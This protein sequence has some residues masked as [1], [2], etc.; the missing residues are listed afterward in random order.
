MVTST[1]TKSRFSLFVVYGIVFVSFFDNHSLLPLI[2]PYARSLGA[3]VALA[4]LIVGAYSA[5]NLLGN[6]GAGYWIDRTGRKLPLV[7]GL[8]IVGFALLLYPF[9][10]DPYA[11][12]GLRTIHGLGAALMSPASLAYIGDTATPK[13]RGRAMALYGAAIGL[14]VLIGPPLAGF[15]RDR[16]GYAYVFAMLSALMFI[17]VVPAYLFIGESFT[18]TRASANQNAWQ[19]L[20]NRRLFLAYTSAF[21]LMFSLGSLIVFLPLIGQ[22]LGLASSR[23]GLLFASFALAAIII[24]ALPFGR[25]SDRWGRERTIMLGLAL[26][27]VALFLLPLLDRWETLMGAMFAYGIGFGFLFPAMTALIADETEPQNRGMASGVFTAVYSLGVTVGTGMA[28]GL[29][30]LQQAAQVHPFQFAALLVVLGF[31]WAG[32]TWRRRQ[33]IVNDTPAISKP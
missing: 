22:E 21:C 5:V 3:S 8:A 29:V 2:S 28:G 19:L 18:R 33:G 23:V 24:Q 11:L 26:I 30:W 15:I 12:L 27:A 6:L 7:A 10:T 4:G 14:T 9:A 31:A 25:I 1:T 16:L 13:T 20:R 17:V 32:V